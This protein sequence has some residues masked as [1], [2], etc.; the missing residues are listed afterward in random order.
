VRGFVVS[1]LPDSK[2]WVFWVPELQS[3]VQSALATFVDFP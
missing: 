1:Y 3:Y 2:G